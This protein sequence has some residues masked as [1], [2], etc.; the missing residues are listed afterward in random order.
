MNVSVALLRC[1]TVDFPGIGDTE[2]NF[3]YERL[4][5]FCQ[6]CGIIGH[7]TKVCDESLGLR[8][9]WEEERP[10]SLSLRAEWDLYG[11]RLGARVGRVKSG[12]GGSGSGASDSTSGFVRRCIEERS[13]A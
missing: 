8:S 10:Y 3:K 12:E 1:T 2:V 4:P 9:K 6:E 13:G 5:E 11:R 7:P